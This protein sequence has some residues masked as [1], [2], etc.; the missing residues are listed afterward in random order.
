MS[1]FARYAER[2]QSAVSDGTLKIIQ[3][4]TS[5]GDLGVVP[6]FDG[7]FY[8]YVLECTNCGREFQSLW[9]L[10]RWGIGIETSN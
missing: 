2:M 8:F 1:D 10:P 9:I 5:L 4:G 6:A 7:G 3:T